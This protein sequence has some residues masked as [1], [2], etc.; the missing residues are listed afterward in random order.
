MERKG[1]ITS[2]F[3]KWLLFPKRVLR[4]L[5]VDAS[6]GRWVSRVVG[7]GCTAGKVR[8][9]PVGG[10]EEGGDRGN[11]HCADTQ[12]DRILPSSLNPPPQLSCGPETSWNGLQAECKAA[13][14]QTNLPAAGTT[15]ITPKELACLLALLGYLQL[16]R[17]HKPKT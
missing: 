17:T 12:G 10:M 11:A 3:E 13:W 16:F 4:V 1:A 9:V 2:I 8:C 5:S 15:C 14:S 7:S 6:P